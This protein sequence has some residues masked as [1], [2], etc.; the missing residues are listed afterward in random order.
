MMLMYLHFICKH[1]RNESV[2]TL[3]LDVFPRCCNFPP[4]S[5]WYEL[6][7]VVKPGD[8]PHLWPFAHLDHTGLGPLV[9]N[10]SSR[11]VVHIEEWKCQYL[12]NLGPRAPL[13]TCLYY[14]IPLHYVY[15][16][17]M[18]LNILRVFFVGNCGCRPQ[19]FHV[20]SGP[21]LRS[22]PERNGGRVFTWVIAQFH[23]MCFIVFVNNR[24][25]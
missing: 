15:M 25:Q 10:S 12:W 23:R 16:L 22:G 24:F 9:S 5:S 7:P 8:G 2:W 1:L 11:F 14:S 4:R 13:Y 21:G 18:F 17:H 19:E 6:I 20:L 3:I